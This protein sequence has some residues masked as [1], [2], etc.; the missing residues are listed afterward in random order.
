MREK[1]YF[2]IFKEKG[3]FF[4]SLAL[5]VW[6]AL[7]ETLPLF[8]FSPKWN[9][10]PRINFLLLFL[11][12]I[13]NQFSSFSFI[14]LCLAAGFFQG[15]LT[16]SILESISLF[17]LFSLSLIFLRRFFLSEKIYSFWLFLLVG[18]T[19][20]HLRDFSLLFFLKEL[21]F[22]FLFLNAVILLKKLFSLKEKKV[23]ESF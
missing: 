13:N 22:N 7:L 4:L 20:F 17:F 14:L 16:L 23:F 1:F 18:L 12:L 11:I 10:L 15:W 9:S 3:K 5:L 2:S 19:I 6:L 8:S 21:L